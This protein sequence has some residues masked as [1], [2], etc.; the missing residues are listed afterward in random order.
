MSVSWHVRCHHCHG[1]W[2]DKL[3]YEY[4]TLQELGKWHTLTKLKYNLMIIIL[5]VQKVHWY[6]NYKATVCVLGSGKMMKILQSI[7]IITTMKMKKNR[8]NLLRIRD[9]GGLLNVMLSAKRTVFS[10]ESGSPGKVSRNF[11][12][13][14]VWVSSPRWQVHG[15]CVHFPCVSCCQ[16]HY[17][18][19]LCPLDMFNDA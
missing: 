4:K 19:M 12:K 7:P 17:Y 8:T 1:Q 6:C 11:R 5:C 15:K 14:I 16:A 9:A 3:F 10:V 2:H 13:C 18:H